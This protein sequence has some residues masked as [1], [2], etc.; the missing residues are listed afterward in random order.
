[1]QIDERGPDVVLSELWRFRR[2]ASLKLSDRLGIHQLAKTGQVE[3]ASPHIAVQ[4]SN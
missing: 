1:M 3:R 2:E 4:I